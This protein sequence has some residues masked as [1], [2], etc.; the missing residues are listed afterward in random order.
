MSG[1]LWVVALWSIA[2]I[3]A[4]LSFLVWSRLAHP[5]GDVAR[6]EPT[7]DEDPEPAEPPEGD[8][9]EATENGDQAS[10]EAT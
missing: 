2:V 3:S 9:A 7:E 8:E 1:T 5:P 10:R 4:A 6:V